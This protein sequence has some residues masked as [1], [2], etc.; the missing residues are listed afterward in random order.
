MQEKL[1]ASR[2]KIRYVIPLMTKWVIRRSLSLYIKKDHNFHD[3]SVVPLLNNLQN[4][5]LK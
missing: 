2:K 5:Y 1:Q 3:A 4:Q